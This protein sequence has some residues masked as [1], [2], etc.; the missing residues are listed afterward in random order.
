MLSSTINLYRNAYAGINRR[1]WLLAVVMLINRSGTMV[2]P[3]MTLYCKHIGYTTGQAGIVVAVYGIGSLVGAF[4]GGKITDRFGFYYTQFF[5]LFC[6]GILFITLGLMNTYL[7]ICICTFFL[8]MVNESFR[9]ANATAIAHYS[10]A[11]NRTQAFSI[12]RLAIN[13][14][15]GVGG[16]LGGLLASVNYHLLFWVDGFTNITASFLL[17][18]LLPKVSLAQQKNITAKATLKAKPAWADKTFMYF[19][20]LQIL[21]SICFFQ[22]FT[23]VPLYF[24]E[25]LHINE[26]WIGILMAMSGIIIALFEMVIVFKLEGTWPYLRL[27]AYGTVI[28]AI[29]FFILNISFING[30]I[31]ATVSML[32]IT[33][34]EMV[35][36]PFMN[37]Y[38]ISRST[39]GN[40]GQ[41][42]GYYTMAWSAA[43]VIG[44][45]S[46]TQIAYAA[47]FNNLWWIIGGICLVTAFGY[48][49]L[50]TKKQA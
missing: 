38:Y 17:L 40:R 4:L 14:G 30:F 11:E 25:S 6:G 8:S 27:M 21:F 28:M 48:N 1:M 19:I 44:S 23:T 5:A 9:P 43:Q 33:I 49:K 47:G 50:L 35:S 46:G 34:A 12:V 24:K 41:Y 3:F 20:G 10:T 29:S 45:A 31:I 37:S 36:M 16:A 32:L 2:L 15:W 18:W 7:S 26:F 22:L 42:A 13:L 39:E